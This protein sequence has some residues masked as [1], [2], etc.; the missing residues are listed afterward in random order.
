MKSL[1]NPES[2]AA[3]P[4][5]PEPKPDPNRTLCELSTGERARVES[6]ESESA[7]GQRLLDLGFLPGTPVEFLRRAPLGD[8][9]C[10]LLRGYQI[11]L[12]RSEARLVRVSSS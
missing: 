8:P 12:R 4:H 6:V 7:M 1:S 2:C 11:C 5:S 10:F 9:L 3:L